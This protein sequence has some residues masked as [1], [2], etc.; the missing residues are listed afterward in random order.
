[1]LFLSSP[2][3]QF[4]SLVDKIRS[5][6]CLRLTPIECHPFIL[7]LSICV[8][9]TCISV[10]GSVFA[11]VVAIVLHTHIMEFK[12]T[13]SSAVFPLINLLFI[14]CFTLPKVFGVSHSMFSSFVNWCY[15]YPF[16]LTDSCL[17]QMK[18][19]HI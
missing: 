9:N 11:F 18:P 4:Y 13:D 10:S 8:H 17:D 14:T 2:E 3:R 19:E 16:M 1:M 15:C 12:S 7:C 5:L 6:V